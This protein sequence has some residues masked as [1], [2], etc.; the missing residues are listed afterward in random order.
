MFIL[1]SFWGMRIGWIYG[2]VWNN[3]QLTK[4]GSI[5]KTLFT[6]LSTEDHFETVPSFSQ[7]SLSLKSWPK[8]WIANSHSL[9]R[10]AFI[11]LT[12]IFFSSLVLF[13]ALMWGI[14]TRWWRWITGKCWR[15][16]C[17][18]AVVWACSWAVWAAG[19]VCWTWRWIRWR[20]GWV[21]WRCRAAE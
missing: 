20:C 8:T 5:K 19:T 18:W 15:V 21:W 6:K 1:F 11:I 9:S 7:L 2:S 13:I 12:G 10:V 3:I 4:K 16:A 17:A 14:L